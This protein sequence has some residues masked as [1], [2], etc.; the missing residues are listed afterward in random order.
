MKRLEL[1]TASPRPKPVMLLS[2]LTP[3]SH[4]PLPFDKLRVAR[5][6]EYAENIPWLKTSGGPK[7]KK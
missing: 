2:T 7:V 5:N 4:R 6:A 1:R 3:Q